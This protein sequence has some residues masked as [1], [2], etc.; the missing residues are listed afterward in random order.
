ME[1]FIKHLDIKKRKGETIYQYLSKFEDKE[2]EK[3]KNL[4]YQIRFNGEKEKLKE[5]KTLINSFL[6]KKRKKV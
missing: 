3:I 4:F 2:I 6:K 1:K 5:L